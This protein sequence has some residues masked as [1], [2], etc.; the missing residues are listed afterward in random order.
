MHD[1]LPSGEKPSLSRVPFLPLALVISL[2][3]LWALTSNLLPVLIPHLKKACRLNLLQSSLVDSAYWIAYFCMAIPA[4]MLMRKWGYKNTIIA[5]LCMA[6]AGAFLF[7]PAAESRSYPFFLAALFIVASGMTF[8][9]TSANP[10]MTVL[11]DPG[12]ASQRL[13]FAQSFN[14][15][16]AFIATMFISKWIIDKESADVSTLAGYTPQQLDLFYSD[17]FDKVKWPY[18]TIGIVLL[19]VAAL[20]VITRFPAQKTTTPGKRLGFSGIW[21]HRQLT[22]GVLAQFFYVGAQ[23]C[24]SSFFI[25]YA[26]ETGGKTEYE[27]TNYLGLLLLSFML[28]RYAGTLFMRFV[29]PEKLLACYGTLCILLMIVIV[30]GRGEM[31]LYAFIA[32][33]FFMSIMFPTIFSLAI[34]GL[35][36]RT[37]W[38]SSLIV[39]SII[40][41][42][43]FPPLLG[44]LYDGMQD[45]RMAYMV[46]LL[47]FIP[48]AFYG[49]S[50]MQM[51]VTDTPVNEE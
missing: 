21:Q 14:G 47:C 51:A 43:V 4:G 39:M 1:P 35:G 40:G 16:G 32:L 7:I 24:V 10:F 25:V 27:A 33:E 38:G 29:R 9:E 46:P 36:D 6:A 15:L 8:L 19:T 45:I 31:T 49:Y 50:R 11:G 20:F 41:G 3:F 12:S 5:G 28:G 23:V 2:F 44:R 22:G 37:E 30:A 42:A 48:V 18:A 26:V 34:R 17:L 13:N